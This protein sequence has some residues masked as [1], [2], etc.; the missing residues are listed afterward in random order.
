MLLDPSGD[1]H[2][3]LEQNASGSAQRVAHLLLGEYDLPYLCRLVRGELDVDRFD[4]ILRD[5]K[6]A[7]LP[8]CGFQL[9]RLIAC[10][11]FGLDEGH[12]LWVGLHEEKGLPVAIEM[13]NARA[14]LHEVLYFHRTILGMEWLLGNLLTRLRHLAQ[15][16]GLELKTAGIIPQGVLEMIKGNSVPLRDVIMLDDFAIW[17]LIARIEVV[18][19]G[20][21]TAVGLA[22]R[23]LQRDPFR[24]VRVE[25]DRVE[26]FFARDP[27]SPAEAVEKV[28]GKYVEGEPQYFY[29]L[30]PA[31][32]RLWEEDEKD[33]ALLIGQ[34]KLAKVRLLSSHPRMKSLFPEEVKSVGTRLLVVREAASE[35]ESLLKKAGSGLGVH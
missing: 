25:S 7:G 9:D 24:A 28:V 18:T 29:K 32:F 22:K 6:M 10:L 17:M 13:L 27:R 8:S 3:L 5:A 14:E 35:V 20:D 21:P 16:E 23:I 31:S 34:G 1:L 30:A 12:R 2:A 33:K 15:K 19:D 11:T 26:A 4:Y